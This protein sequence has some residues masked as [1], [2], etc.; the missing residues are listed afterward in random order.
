MVVTIFDYFQQPMPYGALP[1]TWNIFLSDVVKM[2]TTIQQLL[3]GTDPT[4]SV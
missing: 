4:T 3:A 1:V 2:F